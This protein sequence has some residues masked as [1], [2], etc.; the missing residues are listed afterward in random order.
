MTG[1]YASKQKNG[2]FFEEKN[3]CYETEENI[4]YQTKN[5]R[6]KKRLITYSVANQN[7]KEDNFLKYKSNRK[8]DARTD[9]H[10]KK[11]LVWT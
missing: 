1:I 3:I 5:E 10:E 9:N 2:K 7:R 11:I 6:R 8:V 4:I